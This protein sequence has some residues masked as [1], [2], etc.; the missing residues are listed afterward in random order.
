MLKLNVDYELFFQFANPMDVVLFR[1]AIKAQQ[2]NNQ[3]IWDPKET[4][5]YIKIELTKIYKE[6]TQCQHEVGHRNKWKIL[7]ITCQMP[8]CKTC[9]RKVH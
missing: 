1:D 6:S 5:H 3:L 2:F 4:K 7:S 9:R 8:S